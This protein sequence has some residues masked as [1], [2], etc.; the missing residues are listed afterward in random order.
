MPQQQ[1][2]TTKRLT[3]RKR[4]AWL[5]VLVGLIAVLFAAVSNQQSTDTQ[6]V[7]VSR[8][9]KTT[10][11]PKPLAFDKTAY[12]LT[13]PSSPWVIVNKSHGLNPRSY[14]PEL[15]IPDVSL[16]P[17]R[18]PS[19]LKVST[20]ML[21]QLRKL[22]SAAAADG[23]SLRID[24]A[25]RSYDYQI[26][27]YGNIVK[28]SG[29]AS[30]DEQSARPGY[31]EHQ[32]GLAVDVGSINGTCTL[33]MC[34]GLT[35]AGQWVAAN[36]YKY[37]FIVRYPKDQ[38]AVTGYEYEPWHLRYVGPELAAEMHRTDILTLEKFFSVS[39]GTVY[40]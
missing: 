22:F 17:G 21:P 12:S 6:T 38:M 30:A 15:V 7:S 5:L 29:Q 10:P 2:Y 18:S 31:S 14:V 28:S 32:T 35:A 33:Q 9:H 37:G 24:S 40:K 19:S 23:A 4:I 39:G 20:L 27:V 34:F 25:Y 26:R 16:R 8:S 36:A 11:Q 1:S 3:Y 13:D